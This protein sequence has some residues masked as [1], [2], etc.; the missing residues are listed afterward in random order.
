MRNVKTREGFKY[1]DKICSLVSYGFLHSPDNKR[2]LKTPGIG[3]WIDKHEAQTIVDEAQDEI[4]ELREE[5]AKSREAAKEELDGV[6]YTRR[7]F[8]QERDDLQRRNKELTGLLEEAL[9]SVYVDAGKC[10][11]TTVWKET[12]DL[13]ARIELAI[14]PTESG[15]SE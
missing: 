9:G 11:S 12:V 8:R 3:N 2:I 6:K 14:K 15:A 10:D 13:A 7:K 1:W 5:L 4:N